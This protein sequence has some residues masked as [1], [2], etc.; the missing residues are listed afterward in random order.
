MPALRYKPDVL[1]FRFPDSGFSIALSTN[2][3]S[4]L[5]QLLIAKNRY[6]NTVISLCMKKSFKGFVIILRLP[7]TEERLLDF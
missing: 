7:L 4:S 3:S 2:V 5:A 1:F 6:T